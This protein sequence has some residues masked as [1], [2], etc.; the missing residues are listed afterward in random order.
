[1]V[2]SETGQL[3]FIRHRRKCPA[4]LRVTRGSSGTC[5]WRTQPGRAFGLGMKSNR[6]CATGGWGQTGCKGRTIFGL[7]RYLYLLGLLLA[8]IQGDLELRLL[9]N[10]HCR[11]GL[12]S[13]SKD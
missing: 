1:M 4:A 2:V 5:S 12:G 13:S 11:R 3:S 7:S 8:Q 10:L 9:V 6:R